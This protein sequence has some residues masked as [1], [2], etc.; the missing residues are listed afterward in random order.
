MARSYSASDVV[1]GP[2]RS[3]IQRIPW[4]LR[5]RLSHA[6][7]LQSSTLHRSLNDRAIGDLFERFD[8]RALDAARFFSLRPLGSKTRRQHGSAAQV[9]MA[10][11]CFF[12]LAP[13]IEP[14]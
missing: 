3:G 13:C 10:A 9:M 8:V 6:D 14:L 1:G 2:L 5:I 12:G 11:W 4:A 7:C